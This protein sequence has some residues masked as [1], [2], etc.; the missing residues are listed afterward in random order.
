MSKKGQFLGST[1]ELLHQK[2]GVGT[3]VY[4]LRLSDPDAL[5]SLKTTG[6]QGEDDFHW[7]GKE[8]INRIRVN[9]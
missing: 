2:P 6:V 5:L 7:L 9:Y 8:M 1:Q 4:V 3:A